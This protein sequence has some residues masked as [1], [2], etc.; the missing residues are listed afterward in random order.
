MQYCKLYKNGPVGVKVLLFVKTKTFIS[1]KY[2]F[3]T[4]SY[5]IKLNVKLAH[6][7]IA[8]KTAHLMK[9]KYK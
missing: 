3:S 7:T 9:E 2:L 4:L 1:V 6:H 5:N 8:P